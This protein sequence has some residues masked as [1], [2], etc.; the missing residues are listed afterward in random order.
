[1]VS[2]PF[3]SRKL[4]H[5]GLEMN[6]HLGVGT[7]PAGNRACGMLFP[8]ALKPQMLINLQIKEWAQ[9]PPL[10]TWVTALPQLPWQPWRLQARYSLKQHLGL[11]HLWF[12]HDSFRLP[13]FSRNV[14]EVK[15]SFF[16]HIPSGSSWF[17]FHAIHF[18]QLRFFVLF[19][20][21]GPRLW[22]V[23]IPGAGI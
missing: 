8:E 21:F 3:S 17:Q 5:R 20:G 9:A 11:S 18:D 10:T 7:L 2:L 13:V 19:W 6:G 1:M 22:H 23:E 15:L 12:L 16:H 14:T 4:S